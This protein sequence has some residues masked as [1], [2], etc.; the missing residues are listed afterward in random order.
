LRNYC[1]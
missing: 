1:I